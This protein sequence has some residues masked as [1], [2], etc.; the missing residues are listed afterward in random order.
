GN[1]NEFARG[2]RTLR[3]EMKISTFFSLFF[4]DRKLKIGS[5]TIC[6]TRTCVA[7]CERKTIGI[8]LHY[9]SSTLCTNR[10]GD[11]STEEGFET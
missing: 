7:V 4:H 11:G 8:V 10:T 5:R 3:L 2:E 6:S 9:D 1:R